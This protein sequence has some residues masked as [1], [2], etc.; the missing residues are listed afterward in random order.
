MGLSL[1]RPFL[2]FSFVS[3]LPPDL[4]LLIF[5]YHISTAFNYFRYSAAHPH[6]APTEKALFRKSLCNAPSHW[7]FTAVNHLAQLS[8]VLHHIKRRSVSPRITTRNYRGECR[9]RHFDKGFSLKVSSWKCSNNSRRLIV[10][11]PIGNGSPSSN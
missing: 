3:S 2:L 5:Y 1:F 7:K 9:S 6:P 11:S 10:S 8:S 4:S